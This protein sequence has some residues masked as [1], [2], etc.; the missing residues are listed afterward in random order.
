MTL[1]TPPCR[2][3]AACVAVLAGIAALQ[4][5]AGQVTTTF[6]VMLEVAT[7]CTVEKGADVDFGRVVHS[8]ENQALETNGSLVVRCNATTP[9][10]ISLD[11]GLHGPD[12]GTRHMRGPE[13]ESVPYRIYS[14]AAGNC[15]AAANVQWG[16]GSAGT[17]ILSSTNTGVSQV[18]PVVGRAAL[19]NPR[20]GLYSDTVTATL[21][22]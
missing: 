3:V 4:V 20:S 16:D 18:I 10:S 13:D 21:T 5:H 14:G 22:Y 1:P 17:C 12:T 9:Y 2:L 6:R 8:S 11:R 19:N 15:S 7:V